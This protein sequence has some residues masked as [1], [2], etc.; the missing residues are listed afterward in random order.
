MLYKGLNIFRKNKFIL[1]FWNRIFEDPKINFIFFD[2]SAYKLIGSL[3][4][5]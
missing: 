3:K 1:W 5:Y 4:N 2:K